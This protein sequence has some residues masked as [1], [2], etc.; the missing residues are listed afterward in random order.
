VNKA[1]L[2]HALAERAGLTKPQAA[3]TI[4]ALFSATGLIATELRR[5]GKVQITGFGSFVA[6]RRLARP[7]RD[8]RT[9]RTI[10][11]PAALVPAFRAGQAL[12]AALERASRRS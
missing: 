2:M 12:R 3:K 1:K 6:R 5:G 9:G 10:H 7:G 11:I 8:P 4:A